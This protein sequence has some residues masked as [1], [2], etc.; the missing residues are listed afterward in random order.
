MEP[1]D[2]TELLSDIDRLK[3]RLDVLRPMENPSILHA[4][5]IE[6]TYESCWRRKSTSASRPFTP[7]STATAGRRG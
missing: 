2:L 4:L 6:Y 1:P 3:A 7:S 5:D